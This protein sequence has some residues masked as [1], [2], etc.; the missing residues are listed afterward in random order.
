[1]QYRSIFVVEKL[2]TSENM[3]HFPEKNAETVPQFCIGAAY[4]F[5]FPSPLRLVQYKE[6]RVYTL[7]SSIRAIGNLIFYFQKRYLR[8]IGYAII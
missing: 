8:R 1:M 7:P 5:I 6:N 3:A 4:I 2:K